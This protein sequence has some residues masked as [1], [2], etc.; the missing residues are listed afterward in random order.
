MLGVH[1]TVGPQVQQR[2]YR[3][4]RA[5][6]PAHQRVVVE[7]GDRAPAS[8]ICLPHHSQAVLEQGVHP[9]HRLA[10]RTQVSHPAPKVPQPLG[11]RVRYQQR[12]RGILG[13]LHQPRHLARQLTRMLP[14]PSFLTVPVVEAEH[15]HDEIRDEL[16]DPFITL[17]EDAGCE[18]A[19]VVLNETAPQFLGPDA[20]LL[21]PRTGAL[22]DH[23]VGGVD[24]GR[25]RRVDRGNP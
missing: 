11:Q 14:H 9:V 7:G 6:V 22:I 4:D 5:T 10:W 24:R 12:R 17:G 25:E 3:A 20:E 18:R 1:P 21:R 16:H 8:V 23:G 19:D 15:P 2:L 13:D